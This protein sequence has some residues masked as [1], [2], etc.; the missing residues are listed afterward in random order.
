MDRIA[1]RLLAS[2][3]QG[4]IGPPRRMAIGGDHHALQDGWVFEYHLQCDTELPVA[5]L[6]RML[7][8]LV[9]AGRL[10]YESSE[11][12]WPGGSATGERMHRAAAIDG[13]P[14]G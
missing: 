6:R 7:D 2:L 5:E 14:L 1:D 13:V 11:F 12:V 3:R 8:Q 4:H 10:A 9:A